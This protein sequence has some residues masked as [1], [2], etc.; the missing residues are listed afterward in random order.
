V[1]VSKV[2]YELGPSN[3]FR[4]NRNTHLITGTRGRLAGYWRYSLSGNAG[5]YV[6]ETI[7][8]MPSALVSF[9]PQFIDGQTV[10]T[11]ASRAIM[12]TDPAL[13]LNVFGDG[14]STEPNDMALIRS[15]VGRDDYRENS[16]TL[17][18]AFQADGE[19]FEL[20]G[21]AL[22]LAFGAE[23]REEQV[24]FY[25]LNTIN[26]TLLSLDEGA[27]RDL[28]AGFVELLVPVVGERQQ[29]RGIRSLQLSLAGRLDSESLFGEEVTPKVGLLWRPLRSV[30]LRTTYSEGYKVPSL[31]QLYE[32]DLTFN[33]F[34]LPP[35]DPV[36]GQVLLGAIPAR[37]G[38]N[39]DLNPERSVSWS[40]GVLL[41]PVWLPGLSL[42]V[43]YFD[44]DYTDRVEG[45]ISLQDILDHFPERVERDPQTQSVLLIDRRALNLSRA[46]AE[47]VDLRLVHRVS[48]AE[49]GRF[50]SLLNYTYNISNTQQTTPDSAVIENVDTAYF[51]RVRANASVFWSTGGLEV[52]PT[53]SYESSTR[54][55]LFP[56][57]SAPVRIRSAFVVDL[58]ASFDFDRSALGPFAPWA[59]GLKLTAGIDNL[60]DRRPSPVDGIGGYAKIDPRQRRYYLSVRKSL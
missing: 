48:T 28:A 39:P 46:T 59:Q 7:N 54:N 23:Y 47:G 56:G 25:K 21:G 58:Q 51:P 18:G 17:S 5:R 9:F 27:R 30:A 4:E 11:P 1:R 12:E 60:L 37:Q 22:R 31:R 16:E 42:S 55:E 29:W 26:R 19:L 10:H 57:A 24:E 8:S 20:P 15:L 53:L 43:D 14:R 36:T 44:I 32:P 6:G 49:H 13:A 50:E 45:F 2:F 3:G 41:E 40:A 52:G 34:G 38:G 35:F 33:V